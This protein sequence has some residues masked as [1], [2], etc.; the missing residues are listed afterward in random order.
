MKHP[1]SIAITGASSGIGEA[2]AYEYSSPGV[3][4]A[5]CGRNSD[6]VKS[7][8]DGCRARGAEAVGSVLDVTDADATARWVEDADARAPLDLLIANA[9]IAADPGVRDDQT[10]QIFAVNM[11]GVINTVLPI[12]KPMRDRRC[13]QIAIVS[14][15]AGYRGFPGAPAY[16]ASKAAVKAWGEALRGRLHR[17]GVQVSVICPGYVISRMT[18]DNKFPMP[19]LMNPERAAKII[20]RGL[21]RNSGLIAFPLPM[22]WIAWMISLAPGM[23][24]DPMLRKLPRKE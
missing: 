15:L 22:H 17:D 2:L 7:V 14:S 11:D 19:M 23:M 1:R 18:Q 21:E 20:R 6:R 13:G 8:V 10:K 5:L 16:S 12:L 9:G 3:T 4:L 24:I